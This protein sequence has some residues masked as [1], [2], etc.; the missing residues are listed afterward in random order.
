ALGGCVEIGADG[1]PFAPLSTALRRLRRELPG[2]LAA[3]AEGQEEE[4]A[5]LLPELGTEA[6]RE[7]RR[8]EHGMARL[9]ELTARLLERVAAEHTVI[10]ALE[11]LHWADA[12]TRH[13]LAYLLRTLRTGRLVVLATYRSDDIHRRHPLRPLLA[14]LLRPQRTGRIVVLAAYHSDD[15]LRRHPLRALLAELDRLRTVRRIELGRFTREEVGCQK[16]GIFARE[17]DPDHVGE[18]FERSD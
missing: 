3:A 17:S 6:A 18:I 4:L 11:D 8:D 5:R 7:A 16:A 12:S 13:L 15:I 10:L 9:F 2:E 1:L 14:Y